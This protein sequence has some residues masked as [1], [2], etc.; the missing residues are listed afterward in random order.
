MGDTK[1]FMNMTDDE[2]EAEFKKNKE[3]FGVRNEYAFEELVAELGS[4][5]FGQQFNIEKTIRGNHIQYLNSWI[6]AL[7]TDYTLIADASAQAQKA[8]DFFAVK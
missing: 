2:R 6:K 7:K 8:V 3:K 1:K 4:V 5:L